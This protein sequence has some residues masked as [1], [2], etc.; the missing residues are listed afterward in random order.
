V[1]VSRRRPRQVL[2]IAVIRV[3]PFA[4]GLALIHLVPE[5]I[6][7]VAVLIFSVGLLIGTGCFLVFSSRRTAPS[8]R[9]EAFRKP[10]RI[11]A[12]GFFLLAAAVVMLTL[13]QPDSAPSVLT[14]I[15]LLTLFAGAILFIWQATR[16][17]TKAANAYPGKHANPGSSPKSRWPRS[18]R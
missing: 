10:A 15:L 1:A 6:Q 4:F 9:K 12:F 5:H 11:M 17:Y 3:V 14:Q 18:L 8:A 16:K 7:Q 2:G 13:T